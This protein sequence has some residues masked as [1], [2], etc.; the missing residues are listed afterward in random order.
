MGLSQTAALAEGRVVE[1]VGLDAEA[2]GNVI[3]DEFEPGALFGCENNIFG[4]VSFDPL[5]EALMDRLGKRLERLLAF[6]SQ[7]DEGDEIGEAAGLGASF[8]FFRQ[9]GGEGVP[10][11]V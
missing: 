4:D 3:A 9:D 6:E 8:H 1:V 10:E 7:T 5:D 11:A 2:R